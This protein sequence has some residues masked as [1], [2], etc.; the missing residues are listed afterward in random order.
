MWEVIQERENE[1]SYDRLGKTI[2]TQL[3]TGLEYFVVNRGHAESGA[4]KGKEY[5]NTFAYTINIDENCYL[6]QHR[7]GVIIKS[8]IPSQY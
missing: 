5:S 4:R 2:H 1:M 8:P 3:S 7:Y 6:I